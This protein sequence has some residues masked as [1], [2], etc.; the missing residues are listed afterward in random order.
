MF[1]FLAITNTFPD[2]ESASGS[3]TL[4][5]SH[6]I[7]QMDQNSRRKALNEA[8]NIDDSDEAKASDFG[9]W[10]PGEFD[11]ASLLRQKSKNQGEAGERES[12]G[13]SAKYDSLQRTSSNKLRSN[14]DGS[15]VSFLFF[16][17]YNCFC[18]QYKF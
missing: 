13:G 16:C 10:S 9:T 6:L 3:E 17:I 18:V 11:M 2:G 5:L 4:D 1:E 14:T 7:N 8:D 12:V 15:T